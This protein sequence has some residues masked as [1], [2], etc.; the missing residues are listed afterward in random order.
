[1][2]I[3][4]DKL[5]HFLDDIVNDDLI[6][7]RWHPHGSKLLSDLKRFKNYS[8][9]SIFTNPIVVCHDQEPLNYFHYSLDEITSYLLEHKKQN[10]KS[11]RFNKKLIT[12]YKLNLN[13][14]Q[15]LTL[16]RFNIYDQYILLHSEKNSPEIEN[17]VNYNA[18]PVYYF[19]HALIARDWFRF[20]DVD[21]LISKKDIQ[22]DFLIYQRAWTG[23]RE[24]RLKF[25][26][27]LITSGLHNNCL[28]KF[29]PI[30]NNLHYTNHQFKNINFQI[31]SNNIENYFPKND[32]P[33]WSS[34]DYCTEDYNQTRFE[35]V[36]ETLFDDRRWHLTE[37]IFRPIAC[38]QPFILVS[39]PGALEYLK[40][41]GFKTFDQ[42]INE[43]Y[44]QIND[45][46]KRLEAI[47]E[48]MKHIASM[49]DSEKSSMLTNLKTIT[50]F[51][52]K[53][54]FSKKFY[55]KIINEYLTNMEQGLNQVKLKK[56]KCLNSLKL[57]RK[58]D[59]KNYYLTDQE[60][61]ELLK[62]I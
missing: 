44:D 15:H 21:P 25:A 53:L 2:T 57:L 19:S 62:Q 23:V 47:I 3:P 45:P 8:I 40:S 59:K 55:K 12:L 1:M 28:T 11:D 30:D 22:K 16:N 14:I 43:S 6:I 38:G 18:V 56:G 32:T 17:Y 42:Y 9:F 34:A 29:N 46:V 5:Y 26:E 51:N 58:L 4:L 7:Y 49:T 24:Y 20:A 50:D 13:Y 36:L 54:F 10:G 31:Q 41:Y 48:T 27:Y 35:I 39:T 52:K 61:Q 33:S 37:K 60:Y